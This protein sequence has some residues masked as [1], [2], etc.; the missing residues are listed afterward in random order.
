MSGEARTLGVALEHRPHG[1]DLVF[2]D[3]LVEGQLRLVHCGRPRVGDARARGRDAGSVTNV[4][5]RQ[6]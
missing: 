1:L 2:V 6:A 3:R 4:R 5:W